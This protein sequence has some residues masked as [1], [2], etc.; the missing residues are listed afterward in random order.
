MSTAALDASKTPRLAA[1]L[2]LLRDELIAQRERWPLWL[3]VL[4]GLGI[5]AYFAS[6]QEPPAWL[7]PGAATV[8]L[9]A[10]WALRRFAG[11]RLAA[12]GLL[13]AALGFA[14]AQLRSLDVAAPVLERAWGPA[15]MTAEVLDAEPHERGWRL[16]LRPLEMAGLEA[17]TLPA[18]VRVIVAGL[19]AAPQPGSLI[20]LRASLR[21]PSPPAAPGAFDFAR[22]A[23]FQQLGG[24]GF[25]YGPPR[26]LAPATSETRGLAEAWRLWWTALRQEITQRI[27]AVL[28]GPRGAM[29]AALVT[30]HRGGI[31]EAIEEDMRD[32]GLAH[33]LSISGLHMVLVAGL[34]FF[35]LRAG[36]ALLPSLALARP[37]KKWAA[38]GAAAGAFVYVNLCGDAVPAE[39][40][41]LMVLVV[42]LAVLLDR[43]AISLRLVAVAAAVLL[44]TAPESLMTASFQMSFG[45]VTALIAA[46]EAWQ[47]HRQSR[48]QHGEGGGGP[49]RRAGAYLL[50]TAATSVIAMLATD[51]FAAFHF[52]RLA[53]YGLPANLVAV[54]LTSF[55]IMPWAVLAVLLMPLGLE[56]FA[57][58]PMGWGIDGVIATAATVAA[59][60][61]ALLHVPPMPDVGLALIVLGGLWLCLWQRSWRWLGLAP[62]LFGALSPLAFEPP[63]LLVSGDARQVALRDDEGRLWVASRRGNRFVLETWQR[64]AFA[65]ETVTWP[66]L[67]S[68][69]GGA[70]SCDPLGCLFRAGEWRVAVLLDPAAAADDCAVADL[71]VSLEPL[72]R[73]PCAGPTLVIDRFDLWR[74][75]AHAVWLGANDLRIATTAQAQGDRPWSPFLR[76]RSPWER[77]ESGDDAVKAEAQ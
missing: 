70:L 32:S 6:P 56:A 35:A 63:A 7:G 75:G 73:Q 9:V 10:A 61:G 53:L 43:R 47:R 31:P 20:G 4:L 3:P 8:F 76:R 39:R 21:P 28:E 59:W 19:E 38:V 65:S 67:G 2:S 50:A 51:P 71:V 27:M 13:A 16:Y 44:V 60:P 58:V 12:I 14:A 37:I 46:Y 55:W 48:G 52:Q 33:L 26:F 64:Q 17:A 42:L 11:P 36:L 23:W 74:E 40:A 62:I 5:A 34:L 77:G 1:A 29:A 69:A 68:A 22:Q 15:G 54:P 18:R 57:L 45:A 41:F 30:G 25:T 24:I 49:L 66:A 72:R